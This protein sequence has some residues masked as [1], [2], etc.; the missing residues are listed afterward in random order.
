MPVILQSDDYDRWLDPNLKQIGVLQ[1]LL[2]PYPSEAMV[3]YRVSNKVN[4][5]KNDSPDCQLPLAENI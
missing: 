2:K 1:S 5:P 3:S 4:A